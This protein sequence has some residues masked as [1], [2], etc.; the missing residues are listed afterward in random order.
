MH[1]YVTKREYKFCTHVYLRTHC[2]HYTSTRRETSYEISEN[3]HLV[4][5]SHF[6]HMVYEENAGFEPFINNL[7]IK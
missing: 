7:V 5:R 4:K 1:E 2:I 6:M 3:L